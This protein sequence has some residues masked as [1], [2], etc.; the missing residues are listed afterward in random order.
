MRIRILTVGIGILL[1][2]FI[3]SEFNNTPVFQP[4]VTY[5]KSFEIMDTGKKSGHTE[6]IVRWNDGSLQ[7]ININGVPRDSDVTKLKG[8][9]VLIEYSDSKND[10][11]KAIQITK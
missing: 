6:A 4:T 5:Q 11:P 2:L 7:G 8:S 3:L 9:H 10:Q 1:V